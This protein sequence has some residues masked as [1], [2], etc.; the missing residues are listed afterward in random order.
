ML[1]FNLTKR[2]KYDITLVVDFLERVSL[3]GQGLR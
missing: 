2:A 3:K 1:R